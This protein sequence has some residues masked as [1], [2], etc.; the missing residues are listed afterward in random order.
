MKKLVLFL[1][2]SLVLT[3]QAQQRPKLVVG[4]VVDQMKMEYLYRFS[5]DFSANGFKRIMDGGYTFHNMH[6]N[7]VPTYTAPGHASIYTGTTPATHGIVG[8][9]WFNRATGKE[10]YCTDDAS[11]KT[12][13]DGT[14]KEGAM[15]PKNLLST[16]ITDELRMATNFRGKVIGMSIKD[17][18]AILPAGHFANG[19]YWYSKTGAFIS[20]TFYGASLPEW[21]TEFNNEK[22][23][24]NYIN[25]G[26]DLLKP[27]ATYD[28]S[29]VD[30]NP[31]EGKI[32]KTTGPVFPY[33]LKKINDEKGAD[34]LRTTPFGN[35]ILADLAIRAI[36]KEQLGK[37]AITDFLTVSF[38]ST[39]Y[40]GH[41]FGPRSMELQDTYLRLDQTLAKFLTYLDQTV[42]KD[43]Y[44]LFL[45]ADHAG[46]ENPNYLKDNKYNVKN[47]PSKSVDAALRKFSVATF[48]A[49]VVLN[50]SNFNLFFNKPV[51]KEKGLELVKVK[52]SFKD[53]LMTQ[54]Q[55]K[56]VYTEEEI[57]TSTGDDYFLSFI[58]K[59]YDPKQN[60][61]I[62]ILDK[63][64]YMEYIETGTTH[65]SPNSYD[66]HVPMLFYGW[67][68]PKGNSHTKKHIT[69]IAP[70]LSQLLKIPF[71]NGTEAEVLEE[72]LEKK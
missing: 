18:G 63:A 46:A 64:G 17:R 28:E 40:V 53:Y 48:G 50:Y 15:S 49:D 2:F 5:D 26:W 23:Y 22:R 71:T 58:A 41:T 30:D 43:N 13:G 70:T 12:L 61:D 16:T 3:V 60:G 7:Y 29:L 19:A 8:N 66:T 24:M 11:V 62:F 35:D 72:L 44:V 14:D 59:G 45:T 25:G 57:L 68:V 32:D 4:I 56:R 65:G 38:S 54:D 31:Y 47:V 21:V 55:V 42:G 51:L 39:D 37:D 20:S 6:Y 1:T 10:M 27:V 9:E 52:Q 33:N 67:H 36:D 69:Q 34:V